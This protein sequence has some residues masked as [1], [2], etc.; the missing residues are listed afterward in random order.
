ML[1]IVLDGGGYVRSKTN[2]SYACGACIPGEDSG[3][4]WGYHVRKRLP[5]R[6]VHS[7][8][9]ASLSPQPF[10]NE[11]VE[12][13]VLSDLCPRTEAQRPPLEPCTTGSTGEDVS[14]SHL[15]RET[16]AT[17]QSGDQHRHGWWQTP[18]RSGEPAGSAPCHLLPCLWSHRGNTTSWGGVGP[19]TQISRPCWAA[20]F[21][22]ENPL[23]K[24]QS[25]P[26][27]TVFLASRSSM[28]TC[29]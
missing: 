18:A 24:K 2:L 13:Q 6:T 17:R 27:L 12:P 26:P 21:Q 7:R 14:R 25:L 3:V 19:V 4:E 20:H 9:W 10:L 29:R 16:Q 11:Q 22:Q 8:G 1:G 28:N 5:F 15:F 23:S